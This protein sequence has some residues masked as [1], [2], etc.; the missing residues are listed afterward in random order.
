LVAL[1]LVGSARGVQRWRGF[2]RGGRNSLS[3]NSPQQMIAH[4]QEIVRQRP[5]FVAGHVA[6]AKAYFSQGQF[7]AAEKE[8]KRA[9]ELD[10]KNAT[11]RL[12]LGNFYLSQNRGQEAKDT[13]TQLLA[14]NA[15]DANA[16]Y[17]LG[18]ALA[19][20][21]NHQT[22]IEEYKTVARLDP[23]AAGVNYNLGVSY[24]KLKMYD[25]AIAAFLKEREQSGD[26]Y[27]IEAGLAEVYQA[28]GMTQQ[29]QEAK[30]KAEQL[31][32]DER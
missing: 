8:M 30:R 14:Q 2:T 13:F 7:D 21:E 28:K 5:D 10:P 19:D 17:G 1:A 16:H 32:D 27:E 4:L 15:N 25:D 6:L 9:V 18:L 26:N 29:A 3:E 11:V 23:K 22:A 20:Q 12:E 24:A 31:K